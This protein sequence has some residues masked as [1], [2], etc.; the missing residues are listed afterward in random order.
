MG[1]RGDGI[2]QKVRWRPG[3]AVLPCIGL[4]QS[5]PGSGV[6]AR[7]TDPA[8]ATTSPKWTILGPGGGGA[9]FVPAISPHDPRRVLVA[10]DMTG[11]YVTPD[12]G[13]S[14]RM[15]NLGWRVWFFAFDPR[16]SNTIYAGS[17]GLWRSDDAGRSWQL[18]SPD[19]RTVKGVT[20]AG[21]HGEPTFDTTAGPVKERVTALAVDPADSRILYAA[22]A[23][24]GV[25]ALFLSSDRGSTWQRSTDLPDGGLKI[26]VDRRS[27]E[28]DRTLYVVGHSSVRRREGGQWTAGRSPAG[29]SRLLEVSLGFPAG[30]GAPTAYAVSR[31]A[32]YVSADAGMNWS[33]SPLPG[34]S[35]QLIAVAACLNHPEIAYASYRHLKVGEETYFGVLR[36]ADGGRSWLP[37]RRENRASFAALQNDW[38]TERFGPG[39]GES[40]FGLAVGATDPELCYATDWARTLRT[41]DGGRSWAAVYSRRTPDGSYVSRGLDVTT[42]YGVH[43]DPFDPQ[44]LFVTYTDVG[45]FRSEN[46]GRGWLS[47]T[48]G[49]PREWVNT[50]YWVAFDPQVK[51]RIWAAVS[52]VHDLPRPKMW[53]RRSASTYTGGVCRSE[54]GGRTWHVSNGGMPQTAVTHLLLDLKSSPASRTLYAAGFGRG[55]YK[56][57]DGGETWHLKNAG[58]EGDEP[59]AWQ[60]AMDSRGALYLIVA[61]R[62]DEDE[63]RGPGGDGALYRSTDGAE[64]WTRLPPPRDVNGPN[65]LAIDPDDPQ[66]LY[67]AAWSRP[68]NGRPVGGGIFVSTDGGGTWK[69]APA[70]DQHVYDVTI[71]PRDPNTVY[72]CGFSSSAWKSTDRGRSWLRLKGFNFKWGHRVVPDPLD[73]RSVYVTTFGGSLWHGPADGD[74]DAREDLTTSP[75]QLEAVQPVAAAMQEGAFPEPKSA[76]HRNDGS[77]R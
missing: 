58:I 50:T 3:I 38:V 44:R 71:D 37:V 16:A 49:V 53:R 32:I 57:A 55:V 74:P 64:H 30:G 9:Q 63:D 35:A 46:C 31:D 54:D 2:A 27:P 5:G 47:S 72:A 65:G 41:T 24:G 77:S 8:V 70:K 73:A 39:F 7:R 4:T 18:L 75:L 76:A 61:R 15:F 33:R 62:N 28:R 10:C 19:P 43:F 59:F 48:T 26:Y 42:C 22:I 56:S 21:D 13:D 11:A 68:V 69:S 6:P 14:W 1:V 29:M 23:N 52:G 66:R 34:E 12:A 45:L 67:L 20:L 40:P 25:T 17:A 51:G 60:L 36:T